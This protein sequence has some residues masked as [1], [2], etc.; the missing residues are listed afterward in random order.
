ME[1]RLA[2]IFAA[3]VALALDPYLAEAHASRGLALHVGGRHEEALAEF[4]NN[5]ARSNP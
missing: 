1:R 2:A 3:D 4:D 5:K